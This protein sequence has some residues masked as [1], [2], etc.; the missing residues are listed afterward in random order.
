MPD[1]TDVRPRRPPNRNW[2]ERPAFQRDERQDN[3]WDRG[4]ASQN[5][6]SRTGRRDDHGWDALMHETTIDKGRQTRQHDGTNEMAGASAKT[7]VPPRGS[8]APAPTVGHHEPRDDDRHWQGGRLRAA[9]SA[10]WDRRPSPP[11]NPADVV[12]AKSQGPWPVFRPVDKASKSCCW[13]RSRP[14]CRETHPLSWAGWH[15]TPTPGESRPESREPPATRVLAGT[16]PRPY[17]NENDL[18][19]LARPW[20]GRFGSRRWRTSASTPARTA[21][22]C[23]A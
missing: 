3:R 6:G 1:M 20:T 9:S 7:A 19:T 2:D 4:P 10:T 18:Y 21:R 22:H 11:L 8:L 12:L 16:G 15:C 13:P 14:R 5:Q 17:G 23:K